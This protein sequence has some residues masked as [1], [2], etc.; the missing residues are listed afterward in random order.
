MQRQETEA[1]K[2]RQ[3]N[4]RGLDHLKFSLILMSTLASI[5]VL[6][7]LCNHDRMTVANQSDKKSDMIVHQQKYVDESKETLGN[8]R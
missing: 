2:Q 6:F 4:E 8:A 5:T 1:S 3:F 7:H